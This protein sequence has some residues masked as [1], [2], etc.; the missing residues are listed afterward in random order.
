MHGH[1][2]RRRERHE[3]AGAVAD[4]AG[5]ARH[6]DAAQSEAPGGTL[7]KALKLADRLEAANARRAGELQGEAHGGDARGARQLRA[8]AGAEREVG[9][10][11]E[12][13]EVGLA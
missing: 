1:P 4:L 8:D 9:E 12:R 13:T 11:R 3:A 5:A 6:G 2:L 7:E 10:D